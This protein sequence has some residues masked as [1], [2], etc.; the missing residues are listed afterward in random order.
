MSLASVSGRASLAPHGARRALP[1]S[2][3]PLHASA[4]RA[5]TCTHR[6]GRQGGRGA[7]LRPAR[8]QPPDAD[9]VKDWGSSVPPATKRDLFRQ[10]RQASLWDEILYVY[11]NWRQTTGQDLLLFASL[12]VVL[13]VSGAIFKALLVDQASP[14]D[15]RG[16]WTNVYEVLSLSLS[17]DLPPAS[18]ASPIEQA[19]SVGVASVGLAAFAL[20]LALVEQLVFEVFEDNVR[21]GSRV[22]EQGHVLVLAWC[23]GQRDFEVLTKLLFQLC[24]AYR[25]DGGTVVVVLT[26]RPKLEME[27]HFRQVLPEPQRLGTRFVFRSGSPLVPDD[28]RRVAAADAA[29]TVILSDQSRGP[30]EADAQAIRCAILLDE[31][32]ESTAPAS[33]ANRRSN[34][35]RLNPATTAATASAADGAARQRQR[36]SRIVVELLTTNAVPMCHY[37]C[38]AR[39]FPLPTGTLSARRVAR[40]VQQ[41]LV[42]TIT[43]QIMSFETDSCLYV[44]SFPELTGL[45]FADIAFRFDSATVVGISDRATRR[46]ALNPP[47]DHKLGPEEDLVLL[48]PTDV[49]FPAF[50]PL[51]EPILGTPPPEPRPWLPAAPFVCARAAASASSVRPTPPPPPAGPAAYAAGRDGG[52]PTTALTRDEEAIAAGG[53]L[54]AAGPAAAAR[55]HQGAAPAV[56]AGPAAAS[57]S[58]P[59][60]AAAETAALSPHGTPSQPNLT[61]TSQPVP[62][63]MAAAAAAAAA[64]A[65][66]AANA[67]ATAAS[68]A[69]AAADAAATAAA[70]AN[71]A[72]AA[73]AA[74]A[75]A[76]DAV[77]AAAAATTASPASG[78]SAGGTSPPPQPA[79]TVA[80]RSIVR[81]AATASSAFI[82][83]PATGAAAVTATDS[84]VEV[85][86]A[87]GRRTAADTVA[88]VLAAASSGSDARSGSS[89]APAAAHGTLAG[90]SAAGPVSG[91]GAP[92]GL[93]DEAPPAADG[94][95]ATDYSSL[96]SDANS[97]FGNDD[98]RPPPS[99]L[100]SV[101]GSS[102][103]LAV[104][105]TLEY[106]VPM[107]YLVSNDSTAMRVLL[108]GWADSRFMA[109]LLREMDYGNAALPPGSEVLLM[110]THDPATTLDLVLQSFEPSNITV[111]HLRGDPLQ[112]S[113]MGA[114]VDVTQ[115]KAALVLCDE[116][117]VDPDLN[118]NDEDVLCQGDMLRLDSLIMMVQLNIRK[119]LEDASRPT[120][121]IVCQKVASIGLTRF[122]DRRRPPLGISDNFA[123]FTAKLL[124][125]AAINPATVAAFA[126]FGERTFLQLADAA[127]LAGPGERLSYLQ[128]QRR[129]QSNG[130]VLIGYYQL[131]T[132]VDEPLRNVINPRGARARTTRRVWNRD[133][134]GLTKLILFGDRP[135]PGSNQQPPASKTPTAS[136]GHTAIATV[137]TVSGTTVDLAAATT[138]PAAAASLSGGAAAKEA[139]AYGA[140]AAADAT[141]DGQELREESAAMS[142]EQR[143]EAVAAALAAAAVIDRLRGGG[144]TDSRG[145]YVRSVE[146]GQAP[147]PVL[148]Q[149]AFADEPQTRAS[150][151]SSRADAGDEPP[152]ALSAG[153][154]GSEPGGATD[155]E[156]A[157]AAAADPK[158]AALPQAPGGGHPTTAASGLPMAA[159]VESA[160][161]S[162]VES[163]VAVELAVE[164]V[165]AAASSAMESLLRDCAA[166]VAAGEQA[167]EEA[168]AEE[169]RQLAQE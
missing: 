1:L 122:E 57:T 150:W 19:F 139:A 15:P 6:A 156:A 145:V 98:G 110:N 72:A 10:G 59:A 36:R 141:A 152:A 97:E 148:I 90:T 37:A 28:L 123:S 66:A 27:A 164:S 17:Q 61:S 162:A 116:R 112:R 67:A 132:S 70:A 133:G 48:R 55:W 163:V 77:N 96:G 43:Q 126:T 155:D 117:W 42:P 69:A 86:A 74:A 30:D 135:A 21:Q 34:S 24:Q 103:D 68:A 75:S 85:T 143:E 18:P 167:R 29:T 13:I 91:G 38:S 32:L 3:A 106:L 144:P 84:D 129:A 115:L 120:I 146:A 102:M 8:A 95:D 101:Q 12:F 83:A 121:N 65:T 35:G 87:N 4:L 165:V 76:A 33:N 5:H 52:S 118:D 89:T 53:V 127:E 23:K 161:V 125:M 92:A 22:Y 80:A 54:A 158:V 107:E 149:P 151:V 93:R 168:E 40:I 16:L 113:E 140:D 20:V 138:M 49:S 39:A 105:D 78:V 153:L 154:P 63:S 60:I 51:A 2:P 44:Q 14:S 128:L 111:R 131:P 108:C 169:M 147:Q 25:A 46:A 142:R 47:V 166:P 88:G 56:A 100:Q 157:A 136:N 9:P 62:N 114:L 45:T 71:A 160:V 79:D 81:A 130:M 26:E 82:A 99:P 58:V 124:T 104:R 159:A 109:T 73:A 137:S 50:R 119:L 11:Y 64:A 31:L 134:N 7:L 41:P 94:S